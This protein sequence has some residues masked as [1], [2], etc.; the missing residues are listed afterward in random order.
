MTPEEEIIEKRILELKP[1][2]EQL[3]LFFVIL[4]LFII[5]NII[6][7]VPTF[8]KYTITVL[9]TGWSISLILQELFIYKIFKP[10]LLGKRWEDMV[11]RS[12]NKRKTL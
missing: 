12:L 5:L 1:F 4:L 6:F 3:F 9:L 7:Q 10:T 11:R 2:Y 8:Q